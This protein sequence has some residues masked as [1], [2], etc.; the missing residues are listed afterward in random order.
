MNRNGEAYSSLQ[1]LVED[2]AA[3]YDD[4]V[5]RPDIFARHIADFAFD[6]LLMIESDEI[7]TED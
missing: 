1:M 7:E 6:E 2:W 5:K 3:E 4:L